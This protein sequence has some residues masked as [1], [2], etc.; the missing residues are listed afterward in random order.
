MTEHFQEARLLLA[1]ADKVR[2]ALD[3]AYAIDPT[4]HHEIGR[5]NSHLKHCREMAG[6]HAALAVV[7]AEYDRPGR[8]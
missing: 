6:V 8:V 5:L 4:P 1:E 3:A 7:Q 2:D